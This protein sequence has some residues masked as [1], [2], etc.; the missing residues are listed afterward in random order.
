MLS[1]LYKLIP[2]FISMLLSM[3]IYYF[4]DKKCNITK[5]LNSLIPVNEEWKSFF[6]VCF[7]FVIIIIC[8]ILGIYI[9][10]IPEPIYYMLIG[11]VVGIGIEIST[12]ISSDKTI[13]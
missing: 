4:I 7:M 5:K 8:G 6:C 11:I 1:S 12:N 13:L 2:L 10:S 9:I 3:I